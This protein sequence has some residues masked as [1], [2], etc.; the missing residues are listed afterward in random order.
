[1]FRMASGCPVVK[2]VRKVTTNEVSVFL[3]TLHYLTHF[4]E[5]LH[6]CNYFVIVN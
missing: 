4:L 6:I 5:T 1:M 3:I 2:E